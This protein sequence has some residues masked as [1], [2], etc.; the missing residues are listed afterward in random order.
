M[1]RARGAR[2]ER[3][4]AHY[5]RARGLRLV[6]RNFTCRYGEIDL[7]MRASRPACLVFVEVRYR[8][9]TRFGTPAA[10]V[11]ANK[12]QRLERAAATFLADRPQYAGVAARFDVLTLTGPLWR[13]EISWV[14]DAF[15]T[16]NEG[17]RTI[18]RTW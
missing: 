6:T 12:Q 7:I 2:A 1:S 16:S 3:L 4:A 13:P 8:R 18:D 15:E 9:D 14:R 11:T 5:L 17:R 10:T